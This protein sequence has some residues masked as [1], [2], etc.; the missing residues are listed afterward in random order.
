MKMRAILIDDEKP[1]LMH[2]ERILQTAEDIQ[3]TGK[4][5]SAQEGLDHLAREKVDIVFLDIGMPEMNGLV[6]AEYIQQIDS[7]IRIV[8][9]TAYA[10]Y[11]LEAFELYALDYL[12]KPVD[13]P[14]FTKTLE[15]IRTNMKA[16]TD[17]SASGGKKNE[18]IVLC[19]KRLAVSASPDAAEQK[20][21]WRTLKNKELFAFLLHHKGMWITRDIL[22]ETL[23]SQFTV[24]KAVIHL[25]TSIYQIRKL[26]KESGL[27]ATLEFSLDSYRL[28]AEGLKTD[29]E[30]F[31]HEFAEES[32]EM[33]EVQWRQAVLVLRLYRGHYLEEHDY[34][35]AK[36]R[37]NQLQQRYVSLTLRTAM[38]ELTTGRGRLAVRRL[39]DA[40]EKEPYSEEICRLLM[41]SYAQLG[42]YTELH[43]Y[44]ESFVDFL[45][46]EIDAIPQLQTQQCY[47]QLIQNS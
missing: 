5:L 38:Y 44:Y 20:M 45:H 27:K 11:A 9:I 3:V 19:F 4:F 33:T 13:S 25:H 43:R 39:T 41:I 46:L 21:K 22:L 28:S 17:A 18:P 16:S 10:E 12:L 14:R 29:V 15:R 31:E 35:W 7:S 8:F 6:A 2:L 30:R 32:E 24:D 40:Q 42:D 47:E 26:I 1:A 36:P 34:A 37:R 23:W